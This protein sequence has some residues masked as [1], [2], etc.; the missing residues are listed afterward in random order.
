MLSRLMT[1]KEQAVL[2]I[3]AGALVLGAGAL[4][5]HRRADETAAVLYD[6]ADASLAVPAAAAV[7][8]PPP[9]TISAPP[10]AHTQPGPLLVSIQGAVRRPGVYELRDGDRVQDLLEKAGGALEDASLFNINLAARLVDATTL[11][12]PSWRA[13]DYWS[14]QAAA[15]PGQYTIS[16]QGQAV[17]A[18]Q[19]QAGAGGAAGPAAGGSS[20]SGLINLNTA[21]QEQLESL[22]GIGPKYAQEIIRFRSQSPF[23]SVDDVE[24]VS[25]IGPKRLEAIRP[26]VTVD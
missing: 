7:P 5:L 18:P 3:F 25:G 10:S 8:P 19:E 1:R 21:S 2:G 4:A 12:V 17:P 11:I 20:S 9:S 23:R 13:N 26:L 14:Y 22:P 15:N 6:P 24:Q 16:R